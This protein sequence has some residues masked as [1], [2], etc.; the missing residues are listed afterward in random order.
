MSGVLRLLW[1]IIPGNV[2]SDGSVG[3]GHHR[4]GC[5]GGEPVRFIVATGVIADVIDIAEEERH[6][7]EAL[8]T[9][10]SKTCISNDNKKIHS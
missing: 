9:R 4:N 3:N 1:L 10:T 6:R 2:R 8:D 5:V 7:V